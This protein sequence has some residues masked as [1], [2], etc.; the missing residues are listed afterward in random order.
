LVGG[1]DDGGGEEV[2][3]L[4]KKSGVIVGGTEAGEEV[5][6]EGFER[7]FEAR[8]GKGIRNGA[9]GALS[10]LCHSELGSIKP[11]FELY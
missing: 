1:E 9:A 8:N 4:A 6:A 10:D 11:I 2:V 7:F 5:E 3:A